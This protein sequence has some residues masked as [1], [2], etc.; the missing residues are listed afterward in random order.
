MK[1]TVKLLGLV[2]SVFLIAVLIINITKE[3]DAKDTDNAPTL[4]TEPTPTPQSKPFCVDDCTISDT[5]LAIIKFFEGF[6]PFTYIDAAGHPTI[7][8]GHLIRP[9]ET[10]NEPLTGVA[11]DELLRKDVQSAERDVNR[12]VKVPFLIHQFDAIVSFTFNLGGGALAKSTLLKRINAGRH[13]DVPAQL[14]RWV[15][16]GGKKLRGLVLRRTAEGVLY[17]GGGFSE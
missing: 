2:L 9:G 1:K 13:E 5:G 7:G 11:A 10:F 17:S 16:A 4:L 14:D 12:S 3:G 8:F 15:Y 6:S